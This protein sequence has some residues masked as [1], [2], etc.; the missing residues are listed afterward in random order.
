M[1]ILF[2]L[3]GINYYS[4]L[5]WPNKKFNLSYHYYLF[6]YFYLCYFLLVLVLMKR[7]KQLKFQLW[8]INAIWG[9]LYFPFF[10]L[11][12]RLSENFVL[13]WRRKLWENVRGILMENVIFLVLNYNT[14]IY[15]NYKNETKVNFISPEIIGFFL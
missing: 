11:S 9:K 3:F 7:S 14:N 1:I 8:N 12:A 15:F 2:P 4:I 13:W 6:Q 10:V 5:L